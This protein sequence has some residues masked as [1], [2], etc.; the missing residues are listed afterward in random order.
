MS[1]TERNRTL[2]R[3]DCPVAAEAA[4]ID[5]RKVLLVHMLD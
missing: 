4:P 5:P 2:G 3:E 1:S